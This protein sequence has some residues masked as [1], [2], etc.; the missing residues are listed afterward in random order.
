[1]IV[2]D[3]PNTSRYPWPMRA[4]HWARALLV[5]TL[6][7]LGW[8][9]VSLPDKTAVKFADLYPLHKQLGVTVFIV[10][11][12]ALF[13]RARSRRP[14]PPHG[15]APWEAVV[16]RITHLA[17]MGLVVIVPLMGYAMSS[18]FVDSDGVPFLGLMLPELLPKSK[19]G[20]ETFQWLHR[21]LAYTLLGLITLHVLGALKHRFLDRNGESD[22]LGR[23]L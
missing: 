7:P 5:L 2:Q 10:A 9:M 15:L 18:S 1:M 8:Y 4:L 3:V 21:V 13:V 20:F 23:M 6:V 19:L 14:P 16:S 22:V 17:L 11:T 12:T